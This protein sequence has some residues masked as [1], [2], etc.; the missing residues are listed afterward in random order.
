M[1]ASGQAHE[2]SAT[3]R[4]QHRGRPNGAREGR[5]PRG[6]GVSRGQMTVLRLS[7]F[8]DLIRTSLPEPRAATEIA[9]WGF[10]KTPGGSCRSGASPRGEPSYANHVQSNLRETDLRPRG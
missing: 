3:R 8:V 9:R 4:Y 6:A 10:N 7:T 2:Y 1:V 5:R